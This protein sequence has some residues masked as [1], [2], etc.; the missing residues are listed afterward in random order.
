MDF[1][2][3]LNAAIEFQH[4]SKDW[5][6]ESSCYNMFVTNDGVVGSAGSNNHWVETIDNAH[7]GITIGWAMHC[8]GSEEVKRV[9][10]KHFRFAISNLWLLA[11][12]DEWDYETMERYID[13]FTDDI[14]ILK[15]WKEAVKNRLPYDQMRFVAATYND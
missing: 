11:I 10:M 2:T 8:N 12:W 14:D 7:G 6:K 13:W 9:A 5:N 3:Y 4:A 1:N 15:S